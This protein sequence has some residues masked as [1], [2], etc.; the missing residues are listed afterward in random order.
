[1]SQPDPDKKVR[2]GLRLIEVAYD[3]KS[4]MAE[5]ELNQLRTINKERQSQVAVLESRVAELEAQLRE[6]AERTNMV[7]SERDAARNELKAMQRDMAKLDQFKRSIMQSI[8][9]EDPQLAI[10]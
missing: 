5:H 1:M 10:T 9:D 3:E 6:Q 4:R 7:A 8:K 2:Q